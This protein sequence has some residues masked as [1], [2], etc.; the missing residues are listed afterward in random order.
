MGS[1][2]ALLWSGV[3]IWSCYLDL[4]YGVLETVFALLASSLFFGGMLYCTYTS[5]TRRLDGIVRRVEVDLLLYLIALNA[6]CFFSN[7]TFN[8]N[9][10][11]FHK[12]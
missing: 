1:V 3:T 6:I 8:N 10:H 9:L 11:I 12:Y 5:T 4:D 7:N 2:I